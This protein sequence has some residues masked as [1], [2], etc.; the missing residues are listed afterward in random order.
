MSKT[1][2]HVPTYEFEEEMENSKK[3]KHIDK[4]HQTVEVA[5]GVYSH[6]INE[7]DIVCETPEQKK[8]AKKIFKK[9]ERSLNN[10]IEIED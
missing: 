3:V 1:Y 4:K 9:H 7:S 10:K 5:D 8:V 6:N 2:R